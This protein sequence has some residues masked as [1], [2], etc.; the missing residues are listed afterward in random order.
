DAESFSMG[1]IPT[2]WEPPPPEYEHTYRE[3]HEGYEIHYFPTIALYGIYLLPG[4][5]PPTGPV[6]LDDWKTYTSITACRAEID[7]WGANPVFVQNYPPISPTHVDPGWIIYQ[8]AGGGQRLWAVDAATGVAVSGYW[9]KDDLSGLL[10]WIDQNLVSTGQIAIYRDI[11]ITFTLVGHEYYAKVGIA[12]AHFYDWRYQDC[13]DWI[14][15][16]LAEPP[17]EGI[18]TTLT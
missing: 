5:S 16:R 11:P 2:G 4:E 1:I 7:N 9:V 18:P 3:T 6:P 8:E 12:G 13:L 14:D 17:D 15:D 10:A